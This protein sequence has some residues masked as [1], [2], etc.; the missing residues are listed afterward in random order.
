MAIA[1][2]KRDDVGAGFNAGLRD[3]S[4]QSVNQTVCLRGVPTKSGAAVYGKTVS[5]ADGKLVLVAL[6]AKTGKGV[7]TIVRA[8]R[9]ERTP[10][11][12]RPS[13]SPRSGTGRETSPREAEG[14]CIRW[15]DEPR[16]TPASW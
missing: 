9:P 7:S 1:R 2:E 10:R 16:K 6:D 4:A 11:S 3:T 12:C 13:R 15:A 5:V 8:L 14:R